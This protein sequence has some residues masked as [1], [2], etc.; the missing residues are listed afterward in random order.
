MEYSIYIEKLAAIE[1]QR[2]AVVAQYNV[3]RAAT[4]GAKPDGRVERRITNKAPERLRTICRE[5]F[6]N[7]TQNPQSL[8][9]VLCEAFAPIDEWQRACE[10][11]TR[12]EVRGPYQDGRHFVWQVK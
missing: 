7:A 9:A 12:F 5:A 6:L 8:P 10:M 3:E 11:D 4:A 1:D 2:R